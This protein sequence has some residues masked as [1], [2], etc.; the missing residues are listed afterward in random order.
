[1]AEAKNWKNRIVG[2]GILPARDF[3]ANADNWRI[4]PRAQQESLAGVL[5]DVGWVQKVI[6]NRRT[7][8]AWGASQGVETLVDGHL[9]VTLALRSGDETPV[10]VEY[11]DL[12]PEEESLVLASLDPI[13]A[14][15][16]ADKPKLAELMNRIQ[17]DKPALQEMLSTLAERVGLI[18]LD[19]TAGGEAAPGQSV[20]ELWQGMPEFEQESKEGIILT[21][22]FAN[23]QHRNEFY[24][25]LGL[26]ATVRTRSIWYPERPEEI[27]NQ[28]GNGMVITDES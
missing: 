10:P 2:E 4:H 1:M 6:V 23:E 21:V 8:E 14:M 11:V 27:K 18:D 12:S 25:R 15:A 26:D 13:A 5:D 22:H 3:L 19:Y 16:A 20:E 17:T 9:R 7:S 24:A 28:L